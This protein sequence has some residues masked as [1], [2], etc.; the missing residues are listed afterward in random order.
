VTFHLMASLMTPAHF[1]AAWRLP[2]NHPIDSLSI[3]HFQRLARIA[4]DAG[5]HAI[6]LGDAPALSPDIPH[7]TSSGVD[8][9]GHRRGQGTQGAARAERPAEAVVGRGEI[10]QGRV[11]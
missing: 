4:A 6:F 8:R 2:H 10:G 1:R 3:D 5:L 11:A 9:H 7:N